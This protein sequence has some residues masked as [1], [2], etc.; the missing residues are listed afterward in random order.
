MRTAPLLPA[1]LSIGLLVGC[2]ENNVHT[3]AV[4]QPADPGYASLDEL[5]RAPITETDPYATDPL[6]NPD[7]LEVVSDTSEPDLPPAE[8]TTTTPRRQPVHGAKH[9][10]EHAAGGHHGTPAPTNQR[11]HVVAPGDT[12]YGLAR[13]Y[14]GDGTKWR[15]LW[16][17][18]SGQVADVDA[19]KVGTRLVIPDVP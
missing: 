7:A 5:D 6:V 19:L 15:A 14:Y 13:K 11:I 16:Q 4:G 9:T 8:P 10:N 18:N 17:A 12:F 2:A 3:P 1:I